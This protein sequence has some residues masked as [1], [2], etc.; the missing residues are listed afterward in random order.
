MPPHVASFE[1]YLGRC[2]PSATE[3]CQSHLRSLT[4]LG[5]SACGVLHQPCGLGS[6]RRLSRTRESPHRDDECPEEWSGTTPPSSQRPL[7]ERP[8]IG[9][10][11]PYG[12]S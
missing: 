5:P 11:T 2:A 6:G 7:A 1:A 12:G 10:K 8:V 3:M 9:D 4:Y